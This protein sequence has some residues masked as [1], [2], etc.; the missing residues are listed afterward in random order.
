MTDSELE[1]ISVISARIERALLTK[2]EDA[3]R[4]GDCGEFAEWAA[5]YHQFQLAWAVDGEVSE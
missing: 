5:A 2:L 3:L 4:K 1:D